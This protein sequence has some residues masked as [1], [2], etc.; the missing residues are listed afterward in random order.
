MAALVI[1]KTNFAAGDAIV[2]SEMN[3]NFQDI[4]N[5]TAGDPTLGSGTSTVTVENNLVVDAATTTQSLTVDGIS[6]LTGATTHGSTITVGSSG[7]GHDVVFHSDTGGDNVTWNSTDAKLV[8]T[9]TSATDAL[10]VADGRMRVADRVYCEASDEVT[11]AGTTGALVVGGDGTGTHLAMD[12]N[13]IQA[14]A[15]DTTT[16]ALHLNPHGGSTKTG[17]NL[18]IDY[19]SNAGLTDPAIYFGDQADGSTA[20]I[21]FDDDVSGNHF[22]FNQGG[23]TQLR[24]NASGVIPTLA[25]QSATAVHVN[26]FGVLTKSSSSARYKNV[27]ETVTMSDHLSPNLVDSLSPKMWSYKSDATNYPYISLIAE[28]AHAVSPFLGATAEDENGATIPEDVHDRAII[29][30]LIVA[31]QD[32]RTR[33]AALEA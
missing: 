31:L 9:G 8:V 18:Y 16:A 17:G 28:D 5:W 22:S 11:L 3:V 29:S 6:T 27:D 14:K 4:E 33:I 26:A 30:L 25:T 12:A 32:A 20:I 15:T 21:H 24:V 23:T 2:A 10:V 13:E 19:D 7:T 1:T